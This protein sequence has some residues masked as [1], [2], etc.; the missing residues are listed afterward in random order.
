MFMAEKCDL[1]GDCFVKCQWIDVDRSQSILWMKEIIA[2][3]NSAVLKKCLTCYACNEYCTRGANPFDQ[4]ATLQDKYH[5]LFPKEIVEEM[6]QKYIFSG[7][8]KNQP[9]ADRIMSVC[10][11]GK[12]D[13]HLIQGELYNLP[14]VS[15]KPYFCWIMFSHM[16]A[17]SVQKRHAQKFVDRLAGTGAKEIV[18]FHDDCY[19]MLAKIA[20]DYGITVPFRPI[21][22]SEYL[23]ECLKAKKDKIK[24]LNIDIAYNRP[25][26][27][28]YTPEKE[29]FIDE[30]FELAGVNR[31]KRI[32]D[33]E[34]AL[35]CAS[36][37][38]ALGKGD[39]KPDQEKNFNDA[40]NAGAKAMVCLCPIC[41]H[42]FSNTAVEMQMPLIFLGDIA[43]MAL[44]EL[45][46]SL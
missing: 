16:G 29:H 12:S 35:C 44:G 32:Y 10:V 19:S 23:L 37:K 30:I 7:E 36:S 38:L 42:S 27:S 25:C 18:C 45:A 8:I 46:C 40:K 13:P 20:P 3:K 41:M 9:S 31:V 22:L 1:C 4:I 2:Q 14:Q 6:E 39:P 28:R 33:R 24:P 15:G 11:F 43:R 5:T 17:E 26:A 21:H 34:N